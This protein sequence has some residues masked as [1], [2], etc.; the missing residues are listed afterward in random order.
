MS[1]PLCCGQAMRVRD[2]TPT[3]VVYGCTR[4]GAER[5]LPMARGV[6]PRP[7]RRLLSA[8]MQGAPKSHEIKRSSR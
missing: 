5:F 1:H 4:C 6:A 3:G 7:F 2:Q 8:A